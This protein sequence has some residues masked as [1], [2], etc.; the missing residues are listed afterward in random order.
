MH[1]ACLCALAAWRLAAAAEAPYTLV[2]KL[3]ADDFTHGLGQWRI[4]LEKPG[5]VAAKNGVLSIDVPAGCTVWFRPELSGPVL[6]QYEAA[7][8]QAGGPHDRVSDLNAFWMATDATMVRSGKFADYNS[9]RTYYVGQG[10]N[11]N[12]TTRF[13]RYIGDP[14]L[15]P[16]LPEHDL[17]DPSVMLKPNVRQLIQLVAM[18]PRIQ[19]WAA[20]R[21]IFDFNDPDPYTRG[22]F[23]FRTTQSHLEIRNFEVWRIEAK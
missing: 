12:T 6:I 22:R 3:H 8:I 11:T 14:V 18:G 4:E 9:L 17:G 10:G 23:A 15:R 1:R 13:R 7:A 21:R 16:L 20:G 2:Q 5:A 19:Y